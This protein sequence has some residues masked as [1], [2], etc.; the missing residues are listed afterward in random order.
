MCAV[1]DPQLVAQVEAE[2]AHESCYPAFA[3]AIAGGQAR[4]FPIHFFFGCSPF[5]SCF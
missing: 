5:P 3:K 1:Q 2:L 4:G